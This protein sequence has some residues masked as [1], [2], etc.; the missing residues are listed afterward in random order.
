ME[1]FKSALNNSP[2]YFLY[3]LIKFNQFV[4]QNSLLNLWMVKHVHKGLQRDFF[5]FKIQLLHLFNQ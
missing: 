5:R 4:D 1:N 3:F 2:G